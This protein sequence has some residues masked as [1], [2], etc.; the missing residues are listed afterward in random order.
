MPITGT[1]FLIGSLALAGVFPL[2]GFWSKD[3]ILHA[4]EHWEG[5]WALI[6]LGIAAVITAF[7][8]TR[9]FIRT[10]MGEP[11]DR[12]IYEHTHESGFVMTGPLIFLAILAVVSGF[13]VFG[14]V[15]EAIGGPGGITE[16]IFLEHPHEFEISWDL[17]VASLAIAAVGIGAGYYVYKDG[18]LARSTRAANAQPGLYDMI[19]NKFY[20]DEMY[21]YGID[22]ALLGFSFLVSW[23]DRY[24]VNDTGVD[25]SA[26]ITRYSG[27]VLKYVQTGRLPNY[28]M[29]VVLGVIALAI[30][31]L[32]VRA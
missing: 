20:F 31:G 2:A 23:F 28:A 30:L 27:S 32:A 10:F 21:Q 22:R 14:P 19:R 15:G 12:H 7:Y 3:E 26:Q 17:F 18:S 13:V 29:G 1:T 11:K 24:V 5:G 16:F 4:S 25:G 9:L 6:L 8:T